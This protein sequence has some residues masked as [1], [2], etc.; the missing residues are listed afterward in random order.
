MLG[1]QQ[2]FSNFTR[3]LKSQALCY[4]PDNE[5]LLAD[6]TASLSEP[7]LARGLGFSYSDCCL[8]DNHIIIDTSRLNHLISFDEQ[9]GILI[10][11]G[12]ISFAE[13]FLVHPNFIPPVMPGT[14][15]ATLA[16]GIAND[17]HGKN[18]HKE[19]SL[20]A[21]IEW[22]ELQIGPDSLQCGRQKNKTLFYATIGGLGLTGVIKRVA[23]RMQK[24]SRFVLQTKEKHQSLA[25]L[26]ASMLEK[27]L[28]YDYQVA[29]LDLLNKPRGVLTFANHSDE[30]K[31]P[32]K[33]K[34]KLINFSL[35]LIHGFLIK[36]FNR[37]Y[38]KRQ[39][40]KPG[41]LELSQFNNPLDTID[42]WNYLYGRKG[43]L[44]FQA[45]F[46]KEK[47]LETINA[48]LKT[49]KE[50]KAAPI[51]SVLKYFDKKGLGLLS[52]T[53]PGFTLA[54]DF[55]NNEASQKA[56]LAMNE[57]VSQIGGKIYLAKDLFLE[58]KQFQKQ[59]PQYIELIKLLKDYNAPMASNLS[60]RLGITHD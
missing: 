11:Q 28:S 9:T 35:C 3:S 58:K 48:L 2:V 1:K 4:R 60:R 55:K 51:L 31:K 46:A 25:P 32:K 54:I 52:F 12:H 44:Q 27:G 29:W 59:Y 21:H 40:T 49:M 37:Y 33:F 42:N 16:G 56:I 14:L 17:I 15:K 20:G 6:L 13:L 8:N 45:V 38:F 34:F 47:A 41:V 39:K 23:L 26:L 30:I 24:K 43:L 5:K 19:G 10:C 36:Q 50:H 22:I 53:E 57:L 7:F 18:N